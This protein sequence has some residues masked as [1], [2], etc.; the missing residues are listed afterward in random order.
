[1][2][3]KRDRIRILRIIARM[4]IGG[5][6][7]QVCE[8]MNFLPRE[9]FEQKLVTGF[10]GIEEL[11][12][13]DV[14][15]ANFDFERINHF[16]RRINLISDLKAFR[17]IRRQIVIFNPHIVHTH[18]AK[19]GVL[20]RIAALSVNR[21][22]KIVHTYHGHLLHGYFNNVMTQILIYI[23]RIL[24]FWTSRLIAVGS[25]VRDELLEVQIGKIEKYEVIRP[26]FSLGKIPERKRALS[27]LG[28]KEYPFIVSWV[29]RLTS[30]KAPDRLLEVA[31]EVTKIDSQIRFI[32][33]GDGPLLN[34][35]KS[36]AIA[37][38]LPIEFLGW[39]SDITPI[40]AIT[41]LMILTSLNE[42]T[43]IALI[44]AQLAGIPAISTD[45]GSVKEVIED[46]I[47][48]YCM[49]Y[50][51]I[52]MSGKILELKANPLT[53]QTLG[54][55]AK[56]LASQKFSSKRFITEYASLY[57]SLD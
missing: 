2:Q 48:G 7:I 30:I 37:E 49:E 11:D 50:S 53:I 9:T 27:L 52:G 55:N 33:V 20:G 54:S 5:P 45:V 44:E 47:S 19:A 13:I 25:E 15:G 35:I 40:L 51:T 26:G 42:G 43:P 38:G 1:M 22:I 14:R 34:S 31:R 41:D 8:L 21:R 57:Q 56:N 12:F 28:L 3:E 23:E 10:C 46:S 36:T 4:N 32:V 18:T 29:G 17:Q 16:G 39:K 24:A 6:A